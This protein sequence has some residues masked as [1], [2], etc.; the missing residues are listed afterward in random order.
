MQ[1]SGEH[2]EGGAE[3]CSGSV[4]V[5]VAGSPWSNPLTYGALLLAALSGVGLWAAAAAKGGS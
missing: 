2:S 4:G 3:V 1:L 5:V